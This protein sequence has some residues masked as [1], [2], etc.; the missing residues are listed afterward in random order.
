MD[1]VYLLKNFSKLDKVTQKILKDFYPKNSGI[2]VK[3]HFGEPGNQAAFT[4]E[5]IEPITD[6]LQSLLYPSKP[7]FAKVSEGEV[8]LTLID[9]PVAYMSP[10]ST[11]AGYEKVAKNRGYG[12]LG[13]ILIS[14]EGIKIK[15][16]DFTA[17]VSRPLVESKNVLVISHVK[18]HSCAGFGGT[19]KNLGMGGVT[20]ETKQQEHDL[21]K[22]VL[23]K[24]CQG[25]GACVRDCPAKALRLLNKISLAAKKKIIISHNIC[26]GCSICELTCPYHCLAPKKALYDDLL[27]QAASAVINQLPKKT[28]YINF[29]TKIAKECDCS[30]NSGPIV[31]KD[32]GILFSQNPVAIDKAAIDLINK[33]NGTNLFKEIHHKDPYLQ[34]N[35]AEKYTKWRKEYRLV[36]I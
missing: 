14:N 6:S 12:R 35:F 25:C 31:S 9:T 3:I 19:I 36:E 30:S 32:I 2:T 28:F 16:K 21:C 22:P 1:K 13:K 20:K 26:W 15:T 27:A 24:E 10:R 11:V 23:V 18:G 29:V 8:G 33:V 7:S 34:I 5:D 17:L 4:P